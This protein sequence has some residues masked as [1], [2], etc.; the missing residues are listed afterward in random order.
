MFYFMVNENGETADIPDIFGKVWALFAPQASPYTQTG[1]EH[2]AIVYSV[3]MSKVFKTS[4]PSF[5]YG[6]L[7][8]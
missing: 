5:T 4:G 2:P 8:K 1:E 3:N 6:I 7:I